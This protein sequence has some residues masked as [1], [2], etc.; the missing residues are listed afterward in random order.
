MGVK[1]DWDIESE[2]GKHK[3][4][5][6]DFKNRSRRYLGIFR[7][8][9][10]IVVFLAV[11]AAAVYL[12]Y[13][14]WNQVN[15]RLEDL[16]TETVQAE[17]AALRIGDSE[18]FLNIQRSAS[19]DWLLVQDS[20]F[21][22]YQD[23]KV[24]SDVVLTGNV[25]D[26]E[27]DGQRGRIQVEEI[28]SGVPYV[29]TWFYWRYP[30][31]DGWR[32][33]PMDRT[34]WG[35]DETFENERF[36]IRYRTL[37]TPVA[38]GLATEVERWLDDACDYLDCSNL[39]VITFDII[40]DD[41]F[42]PQW[43]SNETN[44]WQMVIPSPYLGR[45]R[46]DRP[47]NTTM[48]IDTATLLAER[49]V[50]FAMPNGQPIYPSDA[51]FLRSATVAWMVG[52]FVQLNPDSHLIESVAMNYGTDAIAQLLVIMQPTSDMGI[53]A[54]AIGQPSLADATLDWRDFLEWRLNTETNL[55]Q[56]QDEANWQNLYDFRDGGVQQIALGRYN[57]GTVGQ[58]ARV[59]GITQTIA[60]D[61]TPQ[62]QVSV[63]ITDSAS[64]VR[65]EV[66]L[67]NLINNVWKRAS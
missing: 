10:V 39:P 52:R 66:V 12:I 26:V 50:Q 13:Q 41:L 67:F 43:A 27:I 20:T 2:R 34:F 22:Q 29:Q 15:S 8:L 14:R 35:E 47:F 6:E 37:D 4:H 32:H 25:T 44:A 36:I 3:Q 57:A 61:G 49:L 30:E 51:F 63:Q 28:V 45:A 19:D 58:L 55:I 33:V 11:V 53:L 59:M 38:E 5:K 17:V 23:L 46:A 65:E 60:S 54:A 16:L 64:A 62:L 21:D 7:L 24:M 18:S 56:I 1:L 40:T 42:E 31:P 9:F 48:Q